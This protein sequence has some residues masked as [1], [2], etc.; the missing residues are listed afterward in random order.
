MGRASSPPG[1]RP[2]TSPTLLTPSSPTSTSSARWRPTSTARPPTVSPASSPPASCRRTGPPPYDALGTLEDL[3]AQRRRSARGAGRRPTPATP[4]RRRFPAAP[5][6]PARGSPSWRSDARCV[7][8]HRPGQ[9]RRRAARRGGPPD[10]AGRR[11][12]RGTGGWGDRPGPRVALER[13]LRARAERAARADRPR[14]VRRDARAAPDERQAR[15]DPRPHRQARARRPRRPRRP[16]HRPL[17]R[18]DPA[19]VRR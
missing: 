6:G 5:S 18:D 19:H 13:G 7:V 4:P 3:A 10:R 17:R 2:T 8:S 1:R 11:A 14:A 16:R 15:G 9:P 12:P